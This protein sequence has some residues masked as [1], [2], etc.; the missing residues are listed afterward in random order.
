MASDP[1]LQVLG[2]AY[3]QHKC[4]SDAAAK[5]QVTVPADHT[6][7]PPSVTVL[8]SLTTLADPQTDWAD[9]GLP[10]ASPAEEGWERWTYTCPNTC[11]HTHTP[12]CTPEYVYT[13]LSVFTPAYTCTPLCT[14]AYVC[15]NLSVYTPTYTCH[16]CTHLH[17]FEHTC[18]PLCT[19]A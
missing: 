8:W 6:H 19:F 1:N 13:N 5:K 7:G 4:Y 15:T 16:L 14:P 10:R 11:A 9:L 18:T 2:A 3:I 12:L 17:T